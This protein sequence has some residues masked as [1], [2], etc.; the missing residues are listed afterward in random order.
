[1][2]GRVRV[3][4][5]PAPDAAAADDW[6]AG[7]LFC[8]CCPLLAAAFACWC[9]CWSCVASTDALLLSFPLL[10][11]VFVCSVSWLCAV[12]LLPFPCCVAVLFRCLYLLGECSMHAR[13]LQSHGWMVWVES[14]GAWGIGH[15]CRGH[16][17]ER[18]PHETSSGPLLA[19]AQPSLRSKV[20]RAHA[21]ACSSITSAELPLSIQ[22]CG[23]RSRN[24]PARAECRT[25]LA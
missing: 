1:M 14:G 5:G 8:R 13:A 18:C 16:F 10:V 12:L 3:G 21:Q 11:S 23:P 20:Q 22:Q 25:A 24:L 9:C 15:T 17:G 7:V 2:S 4:C 6:C 19:P